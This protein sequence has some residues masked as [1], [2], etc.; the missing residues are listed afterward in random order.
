MYSL[1]PCKLVP[2]LDLVVLV[3]SCSTGGRC[4]YWRETGSHVEQNVINIIPEKLPLKTN[5]KL[6]LTPDQLIRSA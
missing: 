3:R 1:C 5:F 6:K 4:S 2:G